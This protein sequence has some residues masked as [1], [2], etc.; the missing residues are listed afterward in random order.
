[1]YAIPRQQLVRPGHRRSLMRRG[2]KDI[3]PAEILERKRKAYVVNGPL[4]ALQAAGDQVKALL[5][6]PRV[7]KYGYI[8]S[9]HLVESMECI[10]S[11]SEVKE[12][13]MLM[14][15]VV[16]ELWL[17]SQMRYL[18]P[19]KSADSDIGQASTAKA[20]LSKFCHYSPTP[21]RESEA[22]CWK[23]QGVAPQ[24][25]KKNERNSLC[26]MLNQRSSEREM[27]FLRSKV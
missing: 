10:I 6:D 7:V 27:R 5:D 17:T 22:L 4:S 21:S 26:A 16:L 9:L 3:V 18:L 24:L 14:K 2:L 23:H 1:M 13:V 25:L 19:V 8:D 15:A 20:E 11:G 12:W